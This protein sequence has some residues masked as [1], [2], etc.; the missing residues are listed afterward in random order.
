MTGNERI[1]D[2][3]L[4][5]IVEAILFAT[6]RPVT[7]DELGRAIPEADSED[8]AMALVRLTEYY[9]QSEE[10]GVDLGEV[11]GGYQIMTRAS[12][13]D[14]VERFLVGKRR[15]RLSRAALESLATIAYKQ[16]ITRGEI[17]E[18]RGV[19]SGHV[20]H[21]L[22]E[23]DLITVRGRSEALGRPLLYG[24]TTEFL[25]FFGIGSIEDLPNLE[26]FEALTTDDP[27]EDPEI[28]QALETEGLLD[29]SDEDLLAEREGTPFAGESGEGDNALDVEANGNGAKGNG[30]NGSGTNGNGTN[31]SGTNG[32]GTNGNGSLATVSNGANGHGDA[33]HGAEATNGNG[34][35]APGNGNGN[36][37]GNDSSEAQNGNGN[38]SDSPEAKNGS[39]NGNGNGNG[40][41]SSDDANGNGNGS[42]AADDGNG[43][44]NGRASAHAEG[45]N[46]DDT[47][48]SKTEQ[49]A[50]SGVGEGSGALAGGDE[51]PA[52][53][54][55]EVLAEGSEL[56][57]ETDGSPEDGAEVGDTQVDEGASPQSRK[58]D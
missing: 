38:S 27:L 2:Q 51:P 35:H 24:T 58:A 12:V 53:E 43:N 54:D 55:D 47:G 7:L 5:A 37:N 20:I 36:G 21:R 44:G 41:H 57:R 13:G 46:G 22:M 49:G 56:E 23:R 26:E 45:T 31:G 33:E 16:P 19:D 6:D 42:H 18:L 52:F 28:R 17:E 10:R 34:S 40:S 11:A 30:T 25:R 9:E 1:A 32:N 3:T 14:Y 4:E 48:V 15:S 29:E 50:F 8:I 39:G